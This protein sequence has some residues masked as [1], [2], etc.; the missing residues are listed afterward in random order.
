VGEQLR[1]DA[2]RERLV[3]ADLLP[4]LAAVRVQV[5]DRLLFRRTVGFRAVDPSRMPI[6]RARNTAT[7]ETR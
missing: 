6:A 4:L 7:M 3:A 2:L 1:L 5:V